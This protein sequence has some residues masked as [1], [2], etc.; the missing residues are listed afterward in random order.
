MESCSV[1]VGFS[2]SAT[3]FGYLLF[4]IGSLY[5]LRNRHTFD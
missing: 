2:L 3:L 5:P 1:R 4:I